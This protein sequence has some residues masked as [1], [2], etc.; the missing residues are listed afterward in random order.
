MKARQAS[1]FFLSL[2]IPSLPVLILG[3]ILEDSNYGVHS[4]LDTDL[5]L[6]ESELLTEEVAAEVSHKPYLT[7][8]DLDV[9]SNQTGLK[10]F[11]HAALF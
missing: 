11:L 9:Q 10:F 2:A 3:D 7:N 1:S 5:G 4:D 8:Q 6:P